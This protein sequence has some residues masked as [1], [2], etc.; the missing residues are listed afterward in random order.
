MMPKFLELAHLV[1]EHGMPKMQV[2]RRRI[3]ARL[4]AQGPAGFD[5]LGQFLLHQQ[6]AAA[7]LG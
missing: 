6:F 7:A 5:L 1:D 2:R 4:D 3:E